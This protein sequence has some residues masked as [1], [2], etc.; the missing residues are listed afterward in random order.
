MDIHRFIRICTLNKEALFQ[1]FASNRDLADTCLFINPFNYY[2]YDA[3]SNTTITVFTTIPPLPMFTRDQQVLEIE[4][5]LRDGR[6]FW[7][8]LDDT[9]LENQNHILVHPERPFAPTPPSIIHL[10]ETLFDSWLS[11]C[12][13]QFHAQQRL[14]LM[15]EELMS[16]VW[17]PKRLEAWEAS[18]MDIYAM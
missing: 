17:A 6:R 14:S 18:G 8:Q 5:I 9:F 11:S 4:F 13:D 12:L 3:T 2:E 1:N 15:K 10:M 16:V 7:T